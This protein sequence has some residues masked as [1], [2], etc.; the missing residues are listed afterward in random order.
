MPAEAVPQFRLVVTAMSNRGAAR[1]N[2][3]DTIGIDGWTLSALS[4]ASL[5]VGILVDH[6]VDV[7][8]ADGMG[9]HNGGAEASQLA[10][11]TYFVSGPDIGQ[12]LARTS[13]AVHLKGSR[14]DDLHGMATTMVGFRFKPDGTSVVFNV[15]DSRAYRIIEGYLGRLSVD[16]R[17][18]N[19]GPTDAGVVT[20]YLG[21]EHQLVLQPHFHDIALTGG[22]R[23]LLCSDGLHDYIDEATIVTS[24]GLAAHE[25][26]EALLR[27]A[28]SSGAPDNVSFVIVDVLGA[29][30]T[31]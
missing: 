28:F 21:G 31:A 7:V 27:A 13:E 16:D 24:L 12:A 3:E 20:A 9:G 25:S 8:I 22:D 29:T 18:S 2:N 1:E 17:P 15:G 6:E 19:P 4:P 30:E 26:A 14:V 11:S 5:T 23:L 10:V